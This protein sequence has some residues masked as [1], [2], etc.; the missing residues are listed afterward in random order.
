MAR[1]L[2]NKNLP[3]LQLQF[4]L[5]HLQHTKCHLKQLLLV[6]GVESTMETLRTRCLQL[7]CIF[8][9]S[10]LYFYLKYQVFKLSQTLAK[11]QYVTETCVEFGHEQG[12]IFSSIFQSRQLGKYVEKYTCPGQILLACNYCINYTTVD[13]RRAVTSTEQHNQCLKSVLI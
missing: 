2:K 5:I 13:M 7:G 12:S 6:H 11:Y 8:P 1:Y 10:S 9:H 4:H 3:D